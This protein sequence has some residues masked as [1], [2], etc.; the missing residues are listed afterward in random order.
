MGLSITT[1]GRGALACPEV[2]RQGMLHD[3]QA[4]LQ[5]AVVKTTS[6]SARRRRQI[7]GGAAATVPREDVER[8]VGRCL[9]LAMVEPGAAPYLQPMYRMREARRAT[10]SSSGQR[11]MVRPKR[12][13]VAG[14]KPGQRGS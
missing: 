1:E 9:H 8:L 4:Q 5:P 6:R 13:A 10:A 3:I 12:L 14:D 11:I 7:R 2:K